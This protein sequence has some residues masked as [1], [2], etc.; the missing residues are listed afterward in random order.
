MMRK[1]IVFDRNFAF[2]AG[3]AIALTISGTRQMTLSG[4]S[5][6]EAQKGGS[7]S[8]KEAQNA[9]NVFQL[10][11]SGLAKSEAYVVLFVLLCG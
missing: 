2:Q 3:A 10:T 11:T 6:N 1:E 9:H 4:R 7:I 8:H 5:H